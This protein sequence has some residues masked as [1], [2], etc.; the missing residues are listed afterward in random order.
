MTPTA[1]TLAALRKHGYMADVVER[2]NPHSGT[3]H[4]LFGFADILAVSPSETLAV[5]AS[6]APNLSARV[7]KLRASDAVKTCLEAG[8]RV[9]VWTWRKYATAVDRRF[10]RET[11]VEIV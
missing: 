4:D 3:R 8:W 7:N 9:Q 11:I 6:S 2:W 1:R 5:Q 10:W